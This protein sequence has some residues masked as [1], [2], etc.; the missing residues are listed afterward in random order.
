MPLANN[1]GTSAI[2]DDEHLEAMSEPSMTEPINL[3]DRQLLQRRRARVA[4][5]A[6]RHDFLLKHA[7]D[8]L[9][10]RLSLI[11]RS[12]TTAAVLGAD[13][14][15][16][17]H[18]LSRQHG[19]ATVITI[20]PVTSLLQHCAAPT[21]VADA[22]AFPFANGTLDL[23]V[24]PLSLQSVNDLPGAFAQIRHALKPDGLFLAAFVGGQTLHELRQSLLE[25]ESETTGGAS[26]RI[27]PAVDVRE[28]GHLLQR[29]GFALPVV[30]SDS[31]TVTYASP[32]ALMHELRGMGATNVLTQR[33]R[34]ALRRSTL[35]RACEIYANRFSDDKGRIRATFEI[36]TLTAWVPHESQQKPLKPGSATAR[37]VDVLKPTQP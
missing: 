28:I 2:Q 14:G 12:F 15:H 21:V 18:R 16:M 29:T 7:A 11:R 30:D 36:V 27:H 17:A 34:L 25:A 33:S 9:M 22:E 31:I 10:D 4:P 26:P 6:A 5:S 24:A 20:D 13:C 1:P 37:L 23:V 19:L 32:I 8:D 35:F 3:F